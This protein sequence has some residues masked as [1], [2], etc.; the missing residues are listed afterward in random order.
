MGSA[1]HRLAEELTAVFGAILGYVAVLTLL[2]V[3]VIH[4]LD[5]DLGAASGPGSR[6]GWAAATVQPDYTFAIDGD[7][8]E[9][10]KRPELR[11]G[12]KAK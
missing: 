10:A 1:L 11:R 8:R 2:G 7:R 6:S 4:L 12:D 5:I 3:A 9:A